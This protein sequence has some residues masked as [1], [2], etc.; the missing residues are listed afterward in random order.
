MGQNEVQREI[1]L[2]IKDMSVNYEV[3]VALDQVNMEIA[4]GEIVALFGSN[5]AGKSTLLN[6]IIGLKKPTTG[7][8]LF[9]GKEIQLS[10]PEV[11][12]RL[13]ISLIPEDGGIFR[14]LTVEENL[15]LG[16][17]YFPH[18]YQAQFEFVVHLFPVLEQRLKQVAGTLSGGEQRMLAFGKA[19][20]GH[21]QILM[22]DEPSLGLSP[23]FIIQIF[24]TIQ[25]LNQKGYTILLAEQNIRQ[26]LEFAQKIYLLEKGRIVL[27]GKTDRL[28]DHSRIKEAYLGRGQD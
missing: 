6:S 25:K 16:A 10:K 11:V 28:K 21:S 2:E 20:M 27:Q 12:T 7:S 8:I 14:T 24:K 4:K 3:I 22:F 23:K 9:K 15:Q 18:Q 19:L 13:G 17:Y 5:G 1:I 26:T